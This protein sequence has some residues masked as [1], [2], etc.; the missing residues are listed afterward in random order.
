[1]AKVRIGLDIGATAVRAAELQGGDAPVVVR[2]AQVPL[3]EG[4]VEAGEIRQPELVS[5]AIR[6]LWQRGGFKSRQVYMGVGN[7]RVVVRE[8]ALPWLPEKE[9]R[10]SLGFQAQEFIPM[11]VED[12]VLDFDPLGE[13][14]QEGRR[15]LRLILVAAQRAMVNTVVD[16]ALAAKLEP[17][18]VDLVPFAMARAVGMPEVGMEDEEGGEEAIVDIGATVT[19]ILVHE[20]GVT[21]FVRILP[22]GG[23][24]ITLAIARS[25]GV[26]TEVAERLKRG[27]DVEGGPDP[28]E[29]H[30]AAMQR[31]QNFVD[32]VR[33]SLEFYTAQTRGARIG[34]VLVIGGGSKLQGFLELLQERVPATIERGHVFRRAKSQLSLSAEALAEAEPVLAV[35]VGLGIPGRHFA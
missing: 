3:P 10:A 18:G 34:R 25:F 26:E 14:E 22:S 24:D 2:A 13:F 1:M 27:E 9:L 32:E 15:M 17:V 21:R 5:E 12:A 28:E 23:R 8:I 6:E 29:V 16:V 30:R 19:N 31:A 11:P 4:A 33:S 20:R 7:Q 35:A